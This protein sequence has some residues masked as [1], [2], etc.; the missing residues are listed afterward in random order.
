MKKTSWPINWTSFLAAPLSS[1]AAPK[2][3]LDARIDEA[4]KEFYQ[5]SV[6]GKKL[7]EKAA[8]MLVFPTVGK[9]G[10]GIGGEYVEGALI[11]RRGKDPVLQYGCRL[12]G[13]SDWSSD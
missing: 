4:I 11:V 10:F 6:A 3:V 1:Y 9:A 7:A 2:I 8:G 12:S 13:F 5:Y